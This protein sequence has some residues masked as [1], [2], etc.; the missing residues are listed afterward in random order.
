MALFE[1]N[2]R[3]SHHDHQHASRQSYP[4]GPVPLPEKYKHL[5]EALCQCL[6]HHPL[7]VRMTFVGWD[8]SDR[9]QTVAIYICPYQGCGSR[10]GW[11]K[12]F[13]TGQPRRLFIK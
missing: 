11:V 4:Q 12:D 1:K 8:T 5:N 7:P 13:K 10:Q 3:P 9:G 6:Q 2:H